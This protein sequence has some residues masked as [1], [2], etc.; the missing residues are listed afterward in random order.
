MARPPCGRARGEGGVVG[1]GDGADDREA[2]AVVPVVI[3]GA[4]TEALEGSNSRSTGA[5]GMTGRV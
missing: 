2:E 3:S 4:V 5:G 1:S